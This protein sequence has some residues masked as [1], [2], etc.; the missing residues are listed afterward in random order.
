MIS[1]REKE[2]ETKAEWRREEVGNEQERADTYACIG[3]E[4][5]E[6]TSISQRA[7]RNKG[8]EQPMECRRRKNDGGLEKVARA[9]NFTVKIAVVGWG[10]D[11]TR[12]AASM[13]GGVEPSFRALCATNCSKPQKS[14]EGDQ[15]N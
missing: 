11:I 4:K 10:I 9:C 3:Y 1:S 8:P 2:A 6:E 15:F 5:G 13:N 14:G 12:Q 7:Y